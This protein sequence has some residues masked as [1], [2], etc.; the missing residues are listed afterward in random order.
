MPLLTQVKL[1]APREDVV[2]NKDEN[3]FIAILEGKW[4]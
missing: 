3:V 2:L 1:F 4:A